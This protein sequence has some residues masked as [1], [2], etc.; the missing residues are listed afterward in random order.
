MYSKYINGIKQEEI[1]FPKRFA[2][3]E[4]K[5]YGILFYMPDN[6][7]SYDGNHVCIYPERIT[8]LGTVLDD[9]SAFYRK[10][11]IRASIYHPFEKN[12]FKDNLETLNAHGY[13]FTPEDDHRVM[14]LTAQNSIDTPK[15]LDIRV[16]D[17]WDERVASD[18]LIPSGEPWETEVT[19]KR[20]GQEGAYLFVGYID[21]KAVVYS[22]IHKSEHGNTRFDYIV[23][24]NEHRGKG[25]AS[26]L[27]S[28]MA[29][30]CKNNDFPICWQWAGPS[31][32][33]CYK[34]GFREA[35]TIEAGYASLI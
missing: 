4:E 9:I 15:R 35:F 10:L 23:T 1:D 28:F 33:I 34:A 11:G 26:E 22:D 20:I 14:L 6:K 27:L 2:S 17:S 19:R 21:G 31:E 7:D 29:E 8:E 30:Y 25:Y 5:E 18:I 3:Y 13:R 16:L 12:Y 32:H 24:A